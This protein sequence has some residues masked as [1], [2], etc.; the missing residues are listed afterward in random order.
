MCG[1]AAGINVNDVTVVRIS[2]NLS[3]IKDL[4]PAL[5]HA[6]VQHVRSHGATK[7]RGLNQILVLGRVQGDLK[8]SKNLLINSSGIKFSLMIYLN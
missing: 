3:I 6:S 1:K 4:V 7:K 2:S 8:L 5:N